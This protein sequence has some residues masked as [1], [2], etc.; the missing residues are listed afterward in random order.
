MTKPKLPGCYIAVEDDA[1]YTQYFAAAKYMMRP[2]GH[3]E[4][5]DAEDVP[6]AIFAPEKWA[7]AH[8]SVFYLDC[9]PDEE[10]D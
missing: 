1:G 4:L 9:Q 8:R 2:S 5:L 6:V 3:L 7:H 10:P